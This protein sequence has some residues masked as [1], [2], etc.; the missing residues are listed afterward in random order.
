MTL[1]SRAQE[2]PK[3]ST[4]ESQATKSATSKRVSERILVLSSLTLR[5]TIP[6]GGPAKTWPPYV[7]VVSGELTREANQAGGNLQ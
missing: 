4:L 7:I 6:P 1:Q 3:N 5:V 2:S